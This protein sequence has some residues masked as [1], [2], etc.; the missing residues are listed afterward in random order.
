MVWRT[1]TFLITAFWLVMTVLL[2]RVTY[3][4]EGSQFAK[5]PP[6]KVFKMFLDRGMTDNTLRLYHGDKRVGFASLNP[7]RSSKGKDSGDYTLVFRAQLDKGAVEFVDSQV[8]WHVNFTLHGTERWGGMS[9][10]VQ[11]SDVGTTINF[12]WAEGASMPKFTVHSKSGDVDDSMLK[13]FAPQMFGAT[14][15]PVLPPGVEAPPAGESPIQVKAR[16]GVMTLAGQKRRGYVIEFSIMD[17][18]HA[19]AFFTE[20]GE[21][22]LVEMPEGWR[23]LHEVVYNL[24]PGIPDQEP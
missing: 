16:E 14:G 21:L 7:V 4:P 11:F 1:F 17:Q 5:L 22:A 10:N 8:S 12:T 20:A 3:Y 13:M 2:V 18:F 19:K 6:G 15:M 9:G 24:E 23:G